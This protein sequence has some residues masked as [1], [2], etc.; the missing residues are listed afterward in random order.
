MHQAK[1]MRPTKAHYLRVMAQQSAVQAEH[2]T[3]GLQGYALI[4]AQ[5]AAH[6]RQ[7][8]QIQSMSRKAEFKRKIFPEY[9]PWIEGVLN[10]GSGKQDDV[11]MTWLVWAMDMGDFN[12]ALHIA[13]YALMHD[14]AMPEQFNRTVATVTCEEIATSAKKAR[15]GQQPFELSYLKQAEQLTQGF[16]MPDE[17]RA[18]LYRELAEFS[19][20]SDPIGALNYCIQAL[21]LDNR[22]GVK[23]LKAKLEKRLAQ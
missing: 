14:L 2:S 15:D 10:A 1:K 9:R 7:L 22:I 3:A 6:K 18:K 5:L 21:E 17:V 4:A 20:E 13:R 11:V 16:D 12:T 23:G 19:A 8:K